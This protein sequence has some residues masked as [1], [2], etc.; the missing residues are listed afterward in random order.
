MCCGGICAELQFQP[1]RPISLIV[2]IQ[3][4]LFQN[5]FALAGKQPEQRILINKQNNQMPVV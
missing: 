3:I 2:T 1:Q 5:T 4:V